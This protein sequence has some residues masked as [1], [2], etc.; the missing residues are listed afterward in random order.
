MLSGVFDLEELHMSCRHDPIRCIVPPHVLR[1]MAEHKD[2]KIRD[3][4]FRTLAVSAHVRGRR[5]ILGRMSLSAPSTQKRRAIYDAKNGTNLPG[6]AMRNE[7]GPASADAAVNQAYDGL[8]ATYDLYWDVYQRNSIDDRGMELVASIHY[9][10]GF[11]NAFFDGSQMVFGD[12]DQTIF[13]GFTKA[14]D[15]IGHEL[16]HG[17]TQH[18]S[19]LDYQGQSGALNESFSDVFGSL[20]KQ[21]HNGQD[22]ASADWL[23]GAGILAPGVNG[24][25]LRSMKAPGTAYDDSKLGGKDPQPAAMSGYIDTPDDN[26][27]VHLNS[28]IPNHAFF[29][30][31]SAIGGN[32]W[33][34]A[35]HIWY[36]TLLRLPHDAQFQ[37]CANLTTSVAGELYGAGSDQQKA[38][39]NAWAEVE[40]SASA[41]APRS[42][43]R[44]RR[45]RLAVEANGHA[46]LKKQLER[47]A[48]AI[49]DTINA[50]D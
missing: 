22:A 42:R 44:A 15:V 47:L 41:L 4:A 7:G 33:E 43:T 17:V 29:L 40:V 24:T 13:V 1:A 21:Y 11:D 14:I 46:A 16:T 12:G 3:I 19:N 6:T 20:V 5:E 31:A 35:G 37:D 36:N 34:D 27:G 25:A 45:E 50:L 49:R 2:K 18:T 32:A 38:V 39:A 26:G 10:Q 48:G 23:I 28:G 9:D 30:A 8:G